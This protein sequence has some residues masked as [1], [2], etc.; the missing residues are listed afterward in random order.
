MLNTPG[1]D[2]LGFQ[3]F[4]QAQ[5]FPVHQGSCHRHNCLA[6]YPQAFTPLG[7][8]TGIRQRLVQLRPGTVQYHGY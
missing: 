6:G 1:A 3:R 5:I 4:H 8:N 2:A 7:F